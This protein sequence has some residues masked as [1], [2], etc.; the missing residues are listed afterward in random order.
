MYNEI[1]NDIDMLN[2]I[3]IDKNVEFKVKS[4]LNDNYRIIGNDQNKV[5]FKIYKS[6]N[7]NLLKKKFYSNK[8]KE[9]HFIIND[10]EN[11]EFEKYSTTNIISSRVN[12]NCLSEDI[13]LTNSYEFKDFKEG[14]QNLKSDNKVNKSNN[15]NT[16]SAEFLNKVK[17]SFLF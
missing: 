13:Q 15:F 2:E 9:E 14:E 10:E 17:N 5:G 4:N 7:S 6:N 8:F 12:L 11:K 3:E 16:A 1:D